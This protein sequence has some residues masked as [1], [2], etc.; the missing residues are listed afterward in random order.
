[1][2]CLSLLETTQ[3]QEMGQSMFCLSLL[4]TTQ[5]QEMGRS[6]FCLSSNKSRLKRDY[7]LQTS[8]LL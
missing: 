6:M 3:S 5:S 7:D 8:H 2:F 4:E 1:M